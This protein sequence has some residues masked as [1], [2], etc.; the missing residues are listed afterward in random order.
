MEILEEDPENTDFL[1]RAATNERFLAEESSEEREKHFH[2]T[3]SRQYTEKLLRL[4]PDH[5]SGMEHLVTVLSALGMDDEAV[6]QAHRCADSSRALLW[7]LKGDALRRHRQKRIDRKFQSLL[8][9][10]EQAGMPEVTEALIRA[11]IPDGNYQHYGFFLFSHGWHRAKAHYDAGNEDAVLDE[12][13][14]LFTLAQKLDKGKADPRFTAPVFDLLE[15][16]RNDPGIPSHTEQFIH[17]TEYLFPQL[18]QRED[19]QALLA[20]AKE[21]QKGTA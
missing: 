8:N 19:Y 14:S 10:I 15:G 17:E 11:A 4:D 16:F 7:C 12:L 1:F 9:E 21:L 6:A 13:H 3:M 2:W 20:K 5:E 18:A